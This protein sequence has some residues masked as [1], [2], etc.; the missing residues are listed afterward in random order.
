[1]ISAW[2]SLLYTRRLPQRVL[3]PGPACSPGPALHSPELPTALW[4]RVCTPPT[5][6]TPNLRQHQ[7]L[8]LR[9]REVFRFTQWKGRQAFI[10]YLLVYLYAAMLLKMRLCL[11]SHTCTQNKVK[12]HVCVHAH[13]RRLRCREHKC[14]KT[15]KSQRQVISTYTPWL[16]GQKV[17]RRET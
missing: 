5:Q 17:T 14:T 3:L 4:D 8:R 1:M 13:I 9:F 2:F 16:R 15:R 7:K 6:S 11:Y 10:M 12:M